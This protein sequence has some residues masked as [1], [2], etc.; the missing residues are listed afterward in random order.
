M[1]TT[2]TTAGTK[3]KLV[4]SWNGYRLAIGIVSMFK[5]RLTTPPITNSAAAKSMNPVFRDILLLIFFQPLDARE[6]GIH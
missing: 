3:P 4:G 5:T 1:L 2:R 6:L